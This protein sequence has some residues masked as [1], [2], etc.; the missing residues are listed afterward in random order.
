LN[1]LLASRRLLMIE[2]LVEISWNIE[3][4]EKKM[5]QKWEREN[6]WQISFFSDTI[7]CCWNQLLGSLLAF[8]C[9]FGPCRGAPR[10]LGSNVTCTTTTTFRP[11]RTRHVF[12]KK[13][14]N[15]RWPGHWL[16]R[17]QTSKAVT[18]FDDIKLS[19]NIFRPFKVLDECFH[20]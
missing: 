1:Q 4:A 7:F 12:K 15:C 10:F 20:V 11:N 6:L 16:G 19:N 3:S 17:N 13:K 14:G 9:R 8:T 5:K 18:L 2:M